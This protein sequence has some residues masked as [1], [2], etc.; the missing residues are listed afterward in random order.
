MVRVNRGFRN[1]NVM[2]IS[3]LPAWCGWTAAQRCAL[4]FFHRLKRFSAYL[5]TRVG[6]PRLAR[7]ALPLQVAAVCYRRRGN[8][9]EF[10]LVNTDGGGKWTFPKGNTV[11]RLSHSLAARR[12]AAE[13]AGVAGRIEPRPFHF[14]IHSKRAFR[15][16][17]SVQ[18]YVIKAF[19]LKVEDIRKRHEAGRHPTWFSAAEAKKMLAKG[20]EV[21]YGRQLQVVIDRALDHIR[22]ER[23][24]TREP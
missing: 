7:F 3:S 10:L 13:E 11:H 17:G 23:N 21:E 8:S 22:L 20:R 19:L 6:S 1:I 16:P 4:R 12:E 5:C 24:S 14:Y 2:L 18:E 15:E 9:A